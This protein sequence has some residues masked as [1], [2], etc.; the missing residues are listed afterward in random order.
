MYSTLTIS[1]HSKASGKIAGTHQR[2]D[3]IARRSLK[4]ANPIG[5]VNFPTYREILHFEG[6]N[7]PDALKTK[8]PGVDEPMHF[9]I[10]GA[11]DGKLIQMIRD[12]QYNLKEALKNNNETRA[13]FE[14]SWLA[15][16]ITDGLTPAHH[17][18]L[19][20]AHKQLMTEDEYFELFGVPFKGVIKGE[21]LKKTLKANWQYLGTNGYM[22]KHLAFEIGIILTLTSI[23]ADRPFTPE[24][25]AEDLAEKDIDKIFYTAFE[26][27]VALDMYNE[28]CEHGWTV[29]L[30]NQ[31]REILI[32]EIIKT[33]TLAWN[34]VL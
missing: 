1:K 13:A 32:P 3:R 28:F 17:F 22:T 25:T 16:A 33:I 20:E 9:I 18:P 6:T 15:H 5:S 4:K 7:G 10:P 29:K 14:A 11:D 26:K 30:L 12:H 8:S 24:I 27:V 31:S 34:S 2:F 19:E 23:P 21:T